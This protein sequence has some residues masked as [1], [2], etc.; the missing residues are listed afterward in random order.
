MPC[1]RWG[2]GEFSQVL[3]RDTAPPGDIIQRS[4][5][6]TVDN[7]SDLSNLAS[8]VFS[9]RSSRLQVLGVN[10]ARSLHL[11]SEGGTFSGVEL[12]PAHPPLLAGR[13]HN[14]RGHAVAHFDRPCLADAAR[15]RH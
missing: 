4:F 7:A 6:L 10:K 1:L 13:L 14:H 8:L 9:P 15:I 12:K 5:E 3:D 2:S 11:G